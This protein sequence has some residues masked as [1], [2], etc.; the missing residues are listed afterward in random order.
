MRLLKSSLLVWLFPFY[1][2]YTFASHWHL[3]S[4]L[5]W[6]HL[7]GNYHVSCTLSHPQIFLP[8][9]IIEQCQ[10]RGR[11]RDKT[12]YMKLS[13]LH[14]CAVVSRQLEIALLLETQNLGV[15]Y[16]SSFLSSTDVLSNGNCKPRRLCRSC[17]QGFLFFHEIS[18]FLGITRRAV[19][20]A[21]GCTSVNFRFSPG[22]IHPVSFLLLQLSITLH[23]SFS[24][25][26]S[27]WW[28]ELHCV[29][30]PFA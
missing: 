10:N 15:K 22:K 1:T 26:E 28:S 23:F 5:S 12:K 9:N 29:T 30:S 7:S 21:Q 17:R 8:S 13:K 11:S 19:I 16:T 3:L 6:Y 20:K 2:Y 14:L 27:Q 25:L 18:Y 4:L 24:D